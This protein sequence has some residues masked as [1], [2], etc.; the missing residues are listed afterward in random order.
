MQL[1]GDITTASGLITLATHLW[2]TP[3]SGQGSAWTAVAAKNVVWNDSCF[4]SLRLG[5]GLHCSSGC[6]YWSNSFPV[7]NVSPISAL[8]CAVAVAVAGTAGSL[9][10]NSAWKSFSITV[11]YKALHGIG[12]T[13]VK[14]RLENELINIPANKETWSTAHKIL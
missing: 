7:M 11:N 5:L 12:S 14:V 10:P 4:S 2:V 8:G 6:K 3:S 1:Q 9:A 13:A